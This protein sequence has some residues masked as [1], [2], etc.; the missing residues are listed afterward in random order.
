MHYTDFL[1]FE[2]ILPLIKNA[3]PKRTILVMGE[4]G[5]G[6]TSLHKALIILIKII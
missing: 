5:I 4:N 2:Q 1:T 3:G 6:K